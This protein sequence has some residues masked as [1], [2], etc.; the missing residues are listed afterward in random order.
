MLKIFRSYQDAVRFYHLCCELKAPAHLKEQLSRASCS[1]A[2]N[3]SEGSGRSSR[4]DR[5]R[6]YV[7]AFGSLKECQT[8]FDLMKI[9]DKTTFKVLADQLG[10][11]IFRLIEVMK[12]NQTAEP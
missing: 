5:R 8:I 4:K 9:E 6:F 7:M 2:L 3:L 1:I 11:Q 12:E 10:A